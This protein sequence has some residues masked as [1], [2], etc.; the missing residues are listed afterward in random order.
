MSRLAPQIDP[1]TCR[2]ALLLHAVND[3]SFPNFCR[4]I[5]PQL[6]LLHLRLHRFAAQNA[7]QSY[8]E[9]EQHPTALKTVPIAQ[10]SVVICLS[11]PSFPNTFPS[12]KP[13]TTFVCTNRSRPPS[14]LSVS[15]PRLPSKWPSKLRFAFA[16]PSLRPLPMSTSQS[17]GILVPACQSRL[18]APT[19]LPLTLLR[20][21]CA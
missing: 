11:S 6:R 10:T 9:R 17:S 19:S 3:A 18:S 7:L 16:T 12:F 5:T 14:R 2:F 15:L 1:R 20:T 8:V 13:S 4:R 21:L